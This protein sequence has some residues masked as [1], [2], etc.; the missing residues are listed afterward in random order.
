MFILFRTIL[1]H[2]DWYNRNIIDKWLINNRH[3]FLTALGLGSLRLKFGQIGFWWE[4]TS[5]QVMV[6]SPVSS[7][8]GRLRKLSQVSFKRS[9]IP[10][11]R[12]LSSQ[13]NC[14]PN[15]HIFST[16]ILRVKYQHKNFGE[17]PRGTVINES[18]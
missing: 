4:T 3:L 12:T 6:F 5:S 15:H 17:F 18:D 9:L 2:A 11:M 16:T 13:P 7:N 8:G 1:V 14:L 10:L